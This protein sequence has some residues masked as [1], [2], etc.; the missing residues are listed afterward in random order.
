MPI[1][2]AAKLLQALQGILTRDQERE[3]AATLAKQW[4]EPKAL[5]KELVKRGWLTMFQAT[6]IF[7]DQAGALRLGP[8]VLLDL[9]GEGGMGQVYKARQT[10]MDRVVALKVIRA[11]R[12]GDAESVGRFRREIKAVAKLSH[13]NVVH[14]YDAD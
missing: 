4:P 2:S 10:V 6:R 13:P 9:L 7:Q 3:V 5:T 12:V 11:D 1:D 14:A 8:Y